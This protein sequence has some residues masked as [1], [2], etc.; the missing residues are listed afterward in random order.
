MGAAAKLRHRKPVLLSFPLL[1]ITGF[2]S[3]KTAPGA[4]DGNVVKEV[5]EKVILSASDCP[6]VLSDG[7]NHNF[8]LAQL[9]GYFFRDFE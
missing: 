8:V 7:R 3:R 4:A 1:Q 2:D 9:L 5:F 6:A